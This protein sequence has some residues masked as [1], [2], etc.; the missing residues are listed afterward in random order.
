MS[1]QSLTDD[2]A[3][4]RDLAEAGQKAPLLGG[5]EPSLHRPARSA[6]ALSS[7][8]GSRCF[9]WRSRPLR[10]LTLPAPAPGLRF[11]GCVFVCVVG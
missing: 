2:L 3:Y 11:F 7:H 4:V 5:R 9:S 10:L 8:R 1:P 6:G